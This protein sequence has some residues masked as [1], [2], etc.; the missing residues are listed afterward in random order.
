MEEHNVISYT[1]IQPVEDIAMP[2]S[3]SI[4]CF[5]FFNTLFTTILWSSPLERTASFN[6]ILNTTITGANIDFPQEISF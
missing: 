1:F 4:E 2:L 6:D 3:R 5:Q